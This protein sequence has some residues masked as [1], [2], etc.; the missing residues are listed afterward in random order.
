MAKRKL[1]RRITDAAARTEAAS[2]GRPPHFPALKP[3]KLEKGM[4]DEHL[5]AQPG[6]QHATQ[7]ETQATHCDCT[8]LFERPKRPRDISPENAQ[9]EG[10]REGGR[11]GGGEREGSGREKRASGKE[12]RICDDDYDYW[13]RCLDTGP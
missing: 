1:Q 6:V 9:T 10:T 11:E 12:K 5:L 13:M 8:F 4:E 7:N 2:T 3:K